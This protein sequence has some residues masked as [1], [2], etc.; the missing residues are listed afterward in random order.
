MER[1]LLQLK[2]N[3]PQEIPLPDGID[4][5]FRFFY[6]YSASQWGKSANL[7]LKNGVHTR[8]TSPVNFLHGEAQ[9][10]FELPSEYM[11]QVLQTPIDSIVFES[12]E[13]VF[14]DL[15]PD[16]AELSI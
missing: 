1:R 13:L 6:R 14:I 10:V 15:V 12:T 16:S 11:E 3:V 2:P 4:A 8:L 7:K 5:N 9:G